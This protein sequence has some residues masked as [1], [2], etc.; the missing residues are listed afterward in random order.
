MDERLFFLDEELEAEGEKRHALHI[1]G[2]TREIIVLSMLPSMVGSSGGEEK[3]KISCV[4]GTNGG[5]RCQL[6]TSYGIG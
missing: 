6:R 4:G 2:A 3:K 5:R 1:Q